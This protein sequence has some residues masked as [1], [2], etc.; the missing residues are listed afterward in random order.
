MSMT[1]PV[2]D[3]LTR[4][5]NGLH[6]DRDDVEMPAS[7]FKAEIARILREHFAGL[8]CALFETAMSWWS[9]NELIRRITMMTGLE[10]LEAAQRTGRGVLL[11]VG[12]VVTVAGALLYAQVARAA[13]SIGD[14][15]YAGAIAP[16]GAIGVNL[17]VILTLGLWV[18]G[19]VVAVASIVGSI[20]AARSAA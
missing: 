15:T 12:V 19:V 4:I 1:D 11:L 6:A 17:I 7:N 3:F 8:G 18:S 2:A 10:H 16:V 20:S 14:E 13:R 5:R 9:S